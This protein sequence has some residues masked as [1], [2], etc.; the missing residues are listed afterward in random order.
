MVTTIFPIDDSA[1]YCIRSLSRVLKGVPLR[2]GT[3]RF[4]SAGAINHLGSA[5]CIVINIKMDKIIIPDNI[6]LFDMPGVSAGQICLISYLRIHL[7]T[8]SL[9]NWPARVG[10]II[11]LS[12]NRM[13]NCSVSNQVLLKIVRSA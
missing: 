6:R 1:S 2:K 5:L 8:S 3:G 9:S 13:S 11:T 7:L 10:S 4:L 12:L